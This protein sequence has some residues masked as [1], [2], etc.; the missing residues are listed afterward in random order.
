MMVNTPLIRGRVNAHYCVYYSHK[1]PALRKIMEAIAILSLNLHIRQTI[2]E[3]TRVLWKESAHRLRAFY[4]AGSFDEPG[5]KGTFEMHHSCLY[6]SFRWYAFPNVC[7]QIC[8]SLAYAYT[9][10][11]PLLRRMHDPSL[12]LIDRTHEQLQKLRSSPRTKKNSKHKS[13]P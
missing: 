3:G 4:F 8:R 10:A 9:H 13:R 12:L 1:N 2:T 7:T 6:I 5:G 11:R